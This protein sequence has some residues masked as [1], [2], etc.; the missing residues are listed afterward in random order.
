MRIA[1]LA[2]RAGVSVRN[3][4]FYHQLGILPRP[5]LRGRV[6]WYGE[7][8]VERLGLI[9]GLA[10]RGY[11]LAAIADMIENQVPGILLGE[12][13]REDPVTASWDA[14]DA[15]RVTRGQLEH[16]VPQLV[17]EPALLER[18]E[19]LGLVVPRPGARDDVYDVPQPPLLRAG[20][21]LV[22]R[23]VPVLTALDELERLREELGAVAGRFARIVEQDMLPAQAGDGR[24]VLETALD[25]VQQVWP[26]VLVAVGRVLTDATQ[27]AVLVRLLAADAAAADPAAAGAAGAA[28]A[29][30]PGEAGE[31]TPR[32]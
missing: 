17:S 19:E 23:G 30:A 3:I 27:Q 1:E 15:S 10:A 25:L 14:G 9:R 26:S 18:M 28:G 6:G 4:R 31:P 32:T 5:Q 22:A 29:D 16:M 24:P 11:S 2:E 8:H 13:D 7:G 21:G 12:V 20:I